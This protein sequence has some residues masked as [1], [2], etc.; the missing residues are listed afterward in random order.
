MGNHSDLRVKRT[1]LYIKNAFLHL[2]SEQSFEKIQVNDIAQRA[3]INRSTFYLHYRDKY[4]LLEQLKEQ[5][6]QDI[7]GYTDSLNRDMVFVCRQEHTPLP[8]LLA[9]LSYVETFPAFFQL[10]ADSD[11]SFYRRIGQITQQ[12]LSQLFPELQPNVLPPAY[13]EALLTSLLHCVIGQWITRDL[14]ES[15]EQVALLMTRILLADKPI[16]GDMLAT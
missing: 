14:A 5:L 11:P 12:K 4:D 15:K 3:M 9:L 6:I 16:S 2:L 1:E 8:H 7:A 13:S 10:A